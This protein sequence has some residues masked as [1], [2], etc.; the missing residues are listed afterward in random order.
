MIVAGQHR[1]AVSALPVPDADCLVV[2]GGQDPWVLVVKH[3]SSDIVEMSQKSEDAAPLLVVPY[4]DLVV[5]T[6]TDEKWLDF[7]EVNSPHRAVVFIKL[8][9][10]SAHPIVPQLDDPIVKTGKYPRSGGME[11]K[12]LHPW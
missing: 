4:F 5:I 1:D 3:C 2:A 11:G 7:V 8:V 12:P 6:T 10:E 9:Q